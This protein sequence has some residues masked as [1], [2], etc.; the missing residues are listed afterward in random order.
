M[1]RMWHYWAYF[2]YL[3][4]GLVL[5]GGTTFLVTSLLAVRQSNSKRVLAYSTIGNLGLI[6][7]CAGIATEVSIAAGILLLLFHA[8]AK[9]LLFLAVGTVKHELGSEDIE[10]MQELRQRMPL[11]TFAIFAGTFLMVL[12]PFG[13]FMAKWM[14]SEAAV[15]MPLAAILIA[16]GLGATTVYY[17]KWLGGMYLTKNGSERMPL[18]GPG[19]SR[20]FT[21]TLLALIAIG[22]FLTLTFSV[23]LSGLVDPFVPSGTDVD[24]WGTVTTST[25]AVPL[26]ALLIVM[27]VSFVIFALYLRPGKK[28]WDV[29]YS[30]GEPFTAEISG[31]Y[32]YGEK[33]ERMTI[34]ASDSITLIVVVIL[35]V[36]PII[37]MGVGP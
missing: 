11:A 37:S 3:G 30:C 28:E 15:E 34:V 10:D 5:I 23:V 21:W 2:D 20:Y 16:I 33:V 12:P 22:V 24:I 13:L 36:S 29:E 31:Q 7:A 27:L 1:L 8:I 17:G 35:L 25:G 32:L 9:G 18:K 6:F 26:Y 19:M 4:W 14:L